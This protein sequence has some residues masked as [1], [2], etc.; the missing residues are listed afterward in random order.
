MGGV[1]QRKIRVCTT[2]DQR[3]DTI[4]A[5]R[6]CEAASHV[7]RIRAQPIWW[8]RYTVNGRLQCVSSRSV[9]KRVAQDLLKAREREG[10]SDRPVSAP[11]GLIRF[12]DAATALLAD[13]RLN[14]KRSL[15]TL[16][17]RI[18]KHLR[19]F[20]GAHRLTEI[21]TALVRDF[22]TRRQAA[23]ASN[24]TINRDLIT[25]KRMYT[26]AVQDGTLTSKPYI[27]LLIEQNV[28][29]GFFEP[30]QCRRVQRHLPACM[31]GIAAFAFITGWRTP[32]EIL[33]LA[34]RHVDLHAGE[35]RL[36]AGTTKNRE[37]RVFPFTAAL[38]EVLERQQMIAEALRAHGITVR[39]V[40]CYTHG[41]KRGQRIS[42]SAFNHAWNRA[43]VAAGCPDR[44][45]H[46]FRRT[47]VRNLVR[48]GVAERVAMQLTGHKTRAVFER[49]NIVS[50]SDLR[51]A[52]QRLDTFLSGGPGA[53]ASHHA[54]GAPDAPV[55][56]PEGPPVPRG[57]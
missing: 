38:R 9:R 13:Y 2:C 3:L 18:D 6:T 1:Y 19:P 46:D 23:G 43:R 54:R 52:A 35:V 14:A 33:P 26:L 47:A 45:P 10:L 11:G 37:G 40:F 44:I 41:V 17:L 25:L 21:T 39:A 15:R 32:S 42:E 48:A 12:E 30:E 56:P 49:Y 50:P 55:T 24:A 29:R 51:E 5:R 4:A 22:I 20:F 28:R 16:T 34:W 8:L 31:Q 27:P 36:D 57:A 7:I 53:T